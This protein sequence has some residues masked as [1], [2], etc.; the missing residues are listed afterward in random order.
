MESMRRSW[1]FWVGII[2][3]A[4]LLFAAGGVAGVFLDRAL[5][6]R[7]GILAAQPERLTLAA[8]AG[9]AIV[10]VVDGS[11]A[12]TAELQVGD[13]IQSVDGQDIANTSGLLDAIAAHKPGD[14][15]TLGVLHAGESQSQQIQVRLGSSPGDS[16]Q[17]YLGVRVAQ[18]VIRGPGAIAPFGQGGFSFGG[19]GPSLPFGRRGYVYPG[20]GLNTQP[21]NRSRGNQE[22]G[23]LSECPPATSSGGN[24]ES[25]CG[26]VVTQVAQ[27]SP[28]EAAGIQVGDLLLD[29]NSK[30]IA[31][32]SGFVDDIG[33][34]APGAV[35]HLTIYR[36]G[37]AE[38]LSVTATLA[39]RP[40]DPTKAYLGVTVP[41]LLDSQSPS[42]APPSGRQPYRVPL[43]QS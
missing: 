38:P 35:I 22:P 32:L 25:Y 11:P 4:V 34:M 31:S 33:S 37:E 29:L 7:A 3:G 1:L 40:D 13:V 27:G 18:R 16:S 9:V 24:S 26:L 2:L 10:E 43:R 5:P 30:P 41:G 8:H 19:P 14:T 15:V 21:Q 42:P 20:P 36:H 6:S 23:F 28:A 39:E 12:A 17:A